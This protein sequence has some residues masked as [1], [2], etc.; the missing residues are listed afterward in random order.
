MEGAYK[1]IV[2]VKKPSPETKVT[3]GYPILDP[4]K[5]D[6]FFEDEKAI[7]YNHC[8]ETTKV[9]DWAEGQKVAINNS[10]KGLV[11]KF[12]IGWSFLRVEYPAAYAP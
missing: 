11:N 12:K 6:E 10:G 5:S 3:M 9:G 7:N 8:T 4:M 2:G 1:R